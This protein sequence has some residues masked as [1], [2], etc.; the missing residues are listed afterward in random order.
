MLILTHRVGETFMIVDVNVPKEVSMHR[1]EIYQRIQT[2]K[3][4]QTP[5]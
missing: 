1:E 3:S 4:K 2:K 5:Y